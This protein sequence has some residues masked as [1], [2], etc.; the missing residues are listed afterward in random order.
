MRK[1]QSGRV[2]E[3]DGGRVSICGSPA[4]PVSRQAK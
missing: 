2:N 3:L 1:M 4:Y